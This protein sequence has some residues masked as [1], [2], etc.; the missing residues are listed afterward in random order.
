MLTVC[1]IYMHIFNVN[2][3]R[4]DQNNFHHSESTSTIIVIYTLVKAYIFHFFLSFLCYITRMKKGSIVR[5]L[6]IMTVVHTVLFRTICFS[7]DTSFGTSFYTPIS[8][9]TPSRYPLGIALKRQLLFILKI[10]FLSKIQSSVI[11]KNF[12]YENSITG[13]KVVK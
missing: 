6:E 5:S 4:V 12:S 7:Q 8:P 10:K 13:N 11:K 9:M 2:N 3:G 1:I